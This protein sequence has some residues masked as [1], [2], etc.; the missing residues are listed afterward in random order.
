M[1]PLLKRL[2][3]V[4]S[5]LMVFSILLSACGTPDQ[6]TV[7]SG[8]QKKTTTSKKVASSSKSTFTTS[9][10]FDPPPS[11]HGNPWA[12]PGLGG[13]GEYVFDRLFEY[14][15]FPQPKFIPMLGESFKEEGNKTIISLK[16]GIVWSDGKPFTSKDVLTS[17]Y[18]GF[19]AGWPM[20]KYVNT[21]EAPDDYTVVI[22]WR[23]PGP[24]LSVMAFSNF[25]NAPNHIYGKWADQLAPLT[26][27]RDNQGNLDQATSDAVSKIREDVYKYKPD[28]TQ[29]VGTGPY[30]VSNVTASEAILTKNPKFR[31]AKN[32]KI[33]EIRIQR[34]VSLEAYLSMVMAGRYDGE[35]HGSTPDVFKQIQQNHPNMKIMWIPEYSQPSMQFNT[36]KYPV[37]NPVVRKAIVYAIN[38]KAL[39]DI[40]E[41]G[42]Q[43]PDTY[44]T[45]LVPSARDIWLGDFLN[46]LTDY[47]YNPSKAEE[48]LKGIGWKKG[49][50]G[51]WRDEKGQLVQLEVA[52]MNSWPIFFLCGDAITNQ[53][54]K[55]GLK[56]VFKAMELSAY[57]EY[58]D[59]GRAMISFDFR[60]GIGSYGYP[61]EA[62]RNLYVD[63]AVRLGFRSPKDTKPLDITIKLSNGD[64]VKPVGLIDELFYTQDVNRQK[65]IV[66]KLAQAT[67]EYVPFMPIGEKTAPWKL[68]NTNLTGY[69]DD[70]KAPEWYGGAGMRPIAKLI[71]LGKF[72]YKK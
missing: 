55:F 26:A 67:N 29:V 41:P 57:W 40:A 58:L 59:T 3:V 32:V 6:S 62:Y 16:K 22:T 45:G 53:L 28:V 49:S 69:P 38:K 15:P 33:D 14:V 72:Y 7:S 24:I 63:G 65:E 10:Y 51:F 4:L 30:V 2:A 56:T 1:K 46:S 31:D 39:L 8:N 19:M 61:W 36:S 13:I 35:P 50:D 44:I 70:P 52:S 68:Y 66:R 60:A 20:W 47:S 9:D 37:N 43:T 27:K 17:Y 48:L 54:N 23:N 21:I 71:K 34:Y 18:M 25:I 64:V 12:P 11:I 42:T 5:L